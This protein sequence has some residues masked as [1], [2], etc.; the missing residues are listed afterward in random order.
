M[1]GWF[2]IHKS[3][4]VIQYKQTQ[5]QKP[6]NPLIDTEKS[7]DKN[8]TPFHDRSAEETRNRSNVP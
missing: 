8:P 5:G 2:N 4:N 6:H 1:Q 7:I 3:I